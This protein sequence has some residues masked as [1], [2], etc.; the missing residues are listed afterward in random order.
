MKSDKCVMWKSLTT[1]ENIFKNIEN[2]LE[3]SGYQLKKINKYQVLPMEEKLW[4]E[5]PIK[6]KIIWIL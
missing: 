3:T 4:L 1:S 6:V 2:L 5:P